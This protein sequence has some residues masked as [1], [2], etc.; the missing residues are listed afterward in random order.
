MSK[1]YLKVRTDGPE[2]WTYVPHATHKLSLVLMDYGPLTS[3]STDV[4][5]SGRGRP[6]KR[7]A[8]H[9]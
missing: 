5:A 4:S 1:A 3:D 2:N 8:I 9:F 7:V 6:R